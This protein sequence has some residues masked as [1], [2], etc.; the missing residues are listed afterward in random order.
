MTTPPVLHGEEA[1]PNVTIMHY[2]G[3]WIECKMCTVNIE[4]TIDAPPNVMQN[5]C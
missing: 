1:I 4:L 2:I 5:R 3:V